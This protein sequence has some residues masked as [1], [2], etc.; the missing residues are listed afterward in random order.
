[1]NRVLLLN[2][3]LFVCSSLFGQ[4]VPLNNHYMLNSFVFN[5]A[6]AGAEKNVNAYLIRNQRFGSFNSS[7]VNNYLTVDGSFMKDKG[8]L[9]FQLAHQTHGIQQQISSSL[10]YSY[11]IQLVKDHF[12]RLGISAG[13]LDNRIN[14]EAINVLQNDDP[15]LLS[16]RSNVS[17]FD[18][19]AGVSYYYKNLKIGI[20]VPQVI[21]NKAG[22]DKSNS[23][24]YYRLSRHFMGMAQ[25]NF[26]LGEKFNTTPN[27]LVRYVPGAPL[28]YDGTLQFDYMKKIWLSG[29][30]KSNYAIQINL[31]VQ[32]AKQFKI[33]YSYEYI[34]GSINK[35][36]TAVHHEMLIGFTFPSKHETKIVEVK[37][38][39]APH[40]DSKEKELQDQLNKLLAEKKRLED[41]VEKAKQDSEELAIKVEKAENETKELE[42]KVQEHK[43]EKQPI[44]QKEDPI[45]NKEDIPLAKGYN[46]IE[47]D[48]VDSPDGFYV[49]TGVYSSLDNANK[50]LESLRG[51]YPET[52][53]VINQR[54]NYYYVVIEYSLNQEKA[55]STYNKYK[56][57][58]NKDIWILN[59]KKIK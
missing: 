1:M 54:N 15:Y 30:Y 42:L 53:L 6:D 26:K 44:V 5:P 49:I 19:S 38:D 45:E 7:T 48:L 22:I 17:T 10:S 50:V 55:K 25:M 37:A 46:F 58:T 31:G 9:G 35:Y 28:Q 43:E 51:E 20:A 40:D 16:M 8:G 29:T 34:I 36:S 56:Q 59:Y 32:V 52:Y 14:K 3:V 41:E 23:R 13:L 39:P 47:L 11:S 33:G 2:I 4:Q 18:L 27:V 12:L 21:G 57:A 24:G